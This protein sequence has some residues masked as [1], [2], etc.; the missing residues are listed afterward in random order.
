M[1]APSFAYALAARKYAALKRPVSP[2]LELS[3]V[4][5]MINAAEPVDA[6]ALENFY[7][8][9]EPFGLPS[10]SKSMSKS[11]SISYSSSK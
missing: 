8:T 3:S 9:F 1:Q 11:R 6:K 2:A 4:Q 5:H 7:S 10:S